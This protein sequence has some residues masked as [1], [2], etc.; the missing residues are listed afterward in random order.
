MLRVIALIWTALSPKLG[1]H[2]SSNSKLRCSINIYFALPI[3]SRLTNT[4]EGLTLPI[5]KIIFKHDVVS[6]L[7]DHRRQQAN[8]GPSSFSPHVMC[9]QFDW[10]VDSAAQ[11]YSSHM[12]TLSN[13]EQ[14]SLYWMGVPA[15]WQDDA[16]DP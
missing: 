6:I 16:V 4:T 3:L 9:K 8:D 15:E 14:L 12:T 1:R 7:M 5:A 2:F 13:I 10:Q 11:I